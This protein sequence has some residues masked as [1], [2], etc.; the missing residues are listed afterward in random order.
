[1]AVWWG[2]C[3]TQLCQIYRRTSVMASEKRVGSVVLSGVQTI[4]VDNAKSAGNQRLGRE[5]ASA[6]LDR[7]VTDKIKSFRLL[8][9][10]T[11]IRVDNSLI[12]ALTANQDAV[13]RDLVTRLVPVNLFFEG[14]ATKRSFYMEDP[15]GFAQQ[16]RCEL[17]AE[18]L[19]M[20]QRWIDA[21]WSGQKAGC[22]T[23][24]PRNAPSTA[25]LPLR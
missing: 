11:D 24:P 17:I 14:D 8:G 3:K 13:S 1:M 18:L 23:L 6:V 5:I 7:L 2:L 25:V 20:V 21:G 12:L 15:V 16:Y 4:I 10:S 22:F 19:G 9:T